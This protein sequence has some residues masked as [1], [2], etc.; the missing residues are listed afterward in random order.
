[1]WRQ[2]FWCRIVES[3]GEWRVE[4]MNG[5]GGRGCKELRGGSLRGEMRMLGCDGVGRKG[6][7]SKL[8]LGAYSAQSCTIDR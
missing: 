2:E 4:V 3:D 1:M 5:D 8:E 6:D 7:G